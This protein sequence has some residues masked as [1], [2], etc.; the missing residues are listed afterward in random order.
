[1]ILNMFHLVVPL[2]LFLGIWLLPTLTMAQSRFVTCS[3]TDCS[4]CSLASLVNEVIVWLFGI[5]FMIFA[6]LMVVA[7]FG[8]V[9]S[10][11]NTS[12][13]QAAKSKFTNAMIGLLIMMSAWLIVDTIMRGLVGGGDTG[14]PVGE[15]SGWGPWSEVKCMVQTVTILPE[16]L[17]N[18]KAE[19][20]V[21][22]PGVPSAPVDP[23]G[24]TSLSAMGLNVASWHGTNG[25]GRTDKANVDAAAAAKKMQEEGLKKYGKQPFQV[26]AAYTEGVGHSANSQHYKGTAIDFQ[27]INGITLAQVAQLARDAG[28]HYVLIEAKHVHADMR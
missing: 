12:A 4:A 20:V 22:V 1:M 23:S 3:G 14:Q 25:P 13:L 21:P 19:P 17:K 2:T 26:T 15:I 5:V 18:E 28:F 9:T 24:M 8:L 6:V 7:G 10:G 16:D 11:G 27:P